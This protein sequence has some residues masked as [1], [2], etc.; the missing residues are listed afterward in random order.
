MAGAGLQFIN[1][2]GLPPSVH[3]VMLY[4]LGCYAG[5]T[6]LRITKD[7][8]ENNPGARVLTVC[9]ETT[10][11]TFQAPSDEDHVYLI[12]NAFFGDGAAAMIVGA[13]AGTTEWPIFEIVFASQEFVPGTKGALNGRYREMGLTMQLSEKVPAVIAVPILTSRAQARLVGSHARAR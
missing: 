3:W 1:L 8:A 4:N 9:V 6:V 12:G 11:V 13:T 5:G 2:L 7:S 10:V